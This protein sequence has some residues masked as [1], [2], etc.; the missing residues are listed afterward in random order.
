M[1]ID[2]V[3]DA[4]THLET[5]H[6]TGELN[7]NEEQQHGKSEDQT[8]EY[9]ADD[10]D[11][12]RQESVRNVQGFRVHHGKDHKRDDDCQTNLRPRQVV[13]VAEQWRHDEKSA[14]AQ[15]NQ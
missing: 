15:K 9:L 10:H 13:A 8:H 1:G 7:G 4:K 6:L 12:I 14:Y 5:H 11:G 3:D 2:D